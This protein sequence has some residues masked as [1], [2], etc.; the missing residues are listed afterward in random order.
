M[1]RILPCSFPCFL[2]LVHCRGDS[3]AL[4]YGG[5]LDEFGKHLKT[6]FFTAMHAACPP[7][8]SKHVEH[9]AGACGSFTD[10]VFS[11]LHRFDVV[12]VAAKWNVHGLTYDD[13]EAFRLRVQEKK[14]GMKIVFLGQIPFYEQYT[15]KTCP[16]Y[17]TPELR[18]DHQRKL[19]S[20]Y[21]AS[22][23][24]HLLLNKEMAKMA[25]SQPLVY[26][27]DMVWYL[28]PFGQCDT[29]NPDGVNLYSDNG[30]L[31]FK[32]SRM[33]ARHVIRNVG[34]PNLISKALLNQL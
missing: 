28:C 31:S 5:V 29:F 27:W 15:P 2:T 20:F 18:C 33:A 17:L 26:Y 13:L 21:D 9:T 3:H 30:H 16:L 7:M 8:P 11:E 6:S 1:V 10:F 14:A 4:S 25:T 34:I 19:E 32:G 24:P 23:S 12:L 22:K